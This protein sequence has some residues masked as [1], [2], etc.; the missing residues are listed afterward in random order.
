MI[1]S[2]I[3]PEENIVRAIHRTWWDIKDGRK[4]SSIFKGENIQSVVLQFL[5]YKNYFQYFIAG[6]I[7]PQVE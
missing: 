3:P 2:P 4:S 1:R 7:H 5:I 6:W